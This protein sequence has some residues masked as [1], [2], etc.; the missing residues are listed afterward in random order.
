MSTVPQSQSAS[1]NQVATN[2]SLNLT[3]IAFIGGGNMASALIASVGQRTAG[4]V[5]TCGGY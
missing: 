1:T 2:G 3:S 5:D 4:N